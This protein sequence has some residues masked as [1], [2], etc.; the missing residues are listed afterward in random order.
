MILTEIH[1]LKF[2]KNSKYLYFG[3]QILTK[4]FNAFNS[5]KLSFSAPGNMKISFNLLNK[6]NILHKQF[7][8]N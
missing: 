2:L 3:K 4:T 6:R 8:T 5:D 1:E 7:F